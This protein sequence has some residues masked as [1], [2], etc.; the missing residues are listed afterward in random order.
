VRSFYPNRHARADSCH[1][2]QPAPTPARPRLRSHPL[3]PEGGESEGPRMT[4]VQS[5]RRHL[6][7]RNSSALIRSPEVS[8]QVA[9]N[10]FPGHAPIGRRLSARYC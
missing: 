6:A 1:N 5:R 7:H 2:R 10:G 4:A 8:S 9:G 3:P